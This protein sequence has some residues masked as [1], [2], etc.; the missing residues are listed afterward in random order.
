MEPK[1]CPFC[2]NDSVDVFSEES[3]YAGLRYANVYCGECGSEG[4]H[5]DL[6]N[7]DSEEYDG[8]DEREFLIQKAIEAWNK[9]G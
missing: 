7:F 9:R 3:Y 8:L 4:P 1:N 2:L 5:I 6:D